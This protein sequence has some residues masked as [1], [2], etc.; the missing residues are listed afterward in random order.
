MV[1]TKW[2]RRKVEIFAIPLYSLF[3]HQ[4]LEKFSDDIKWRRVRRCREIAKC[5]WSPLPLSLRLFLVLQQ[6]LHIRQWYLG[7]LVAKQNVKYDPKASQVILVS[8]ALGNLRF[9]HCSSKNCYTMLS[10][11]LNNISSIHI[12]Q[13]CN[14]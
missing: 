4:Q 7:L 6:I 3:D 14:R 1:L 5:K 8:Y 2:Q 11:S 13:Y 12:V 10:Q 9:P